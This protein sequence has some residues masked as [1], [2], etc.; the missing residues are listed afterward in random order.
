MLLLFG[1]TIIILAI[2]SVILSAG[3]VL[4]SPLSM[5]LIFSIAV[6]LAMIIL[7]I[8]IAKGKIG[9]FSARGGDEDREQEFLYI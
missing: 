7:A 8:L 3:D 4:Y 5:L 9:F 2:F 6:G 1:Y